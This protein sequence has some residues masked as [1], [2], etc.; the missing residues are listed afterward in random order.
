VSVSSAGGA[1]RRR[2]LRRPVRSGT[3]AGCR[4]GTLG[5][6]PDLAL[7]VLEV[8]EDGARLTVTAA[9]AAGEE[10]EVSLLPP[11]L[12]RP[13]VRFA[14]VIWCAPAGGSSFWVGVRFREPLTYADLLHLT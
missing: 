13:L 11:G 4:A 10:V 8:S 1:E 2:A 7:A 5:L 12:S 6:G 9:L 3:A 14:D